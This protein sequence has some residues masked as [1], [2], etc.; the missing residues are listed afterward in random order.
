LL[1]AAPANLSRLDE[2]HIDWRVLVFGLALFLVASFLTGLVPALRLGR[3]DPQ[4]ALRYASA[5]ASRGFETP[6]PAKR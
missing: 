5:G 3:L 6:A 4:T 2:V 1:A